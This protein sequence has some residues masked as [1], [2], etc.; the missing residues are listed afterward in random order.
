MNLGVSIDITFTLS[1]SHSASRSVICSE[2]LL[3]VSVRAELFCLLVLMESLHFV[4]RASS[5]FTFSEIEKE[6]KLSKDRM[7]QQHIGYRDT[8]CSC[9]SLYCLERNMF[10][11]KYEIDKP[12]IND[13]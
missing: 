5:R 11:Y 13:P 6:N 8:S 4:S 10:Q 1:L 12:L 2:R 3:F 9:L 7:K